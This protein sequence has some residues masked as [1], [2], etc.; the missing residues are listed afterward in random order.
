M[1]IN[2][3]FTRS[4]CRFGNLFIFAMMLHM[5]STKNDLKCEYKHFDDIRKLGICLH[6]GNKTHSKTIKCT[7]VNCVELIQNN[8]YD[9]NVEIDGESYYQ[10]PEFAV[11]ITK[12]L[13]ENN[14][15]TQI[16][17]ANPFKKRYGVNNDLFVHIRLGDISHDPKRCKSFEYY[18]EVISKQTFDKGYVTSDSFNH[19]TVKRLIEKHNLRIFNDNIINTIQF[20]STC[21]HVVLSNGTFSWLIGVLSFNSIVSYPQ[22]NSEWHGNLYVDPSWIQY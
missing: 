10:T 21:K 20:G 14:Q 16:M 1:A 7:D 3:T 15:K 12:L 11:L 8:E 17:D 18:D 4:S 13:H 22:M 5:I 19:P 6:V 9:F 2:S